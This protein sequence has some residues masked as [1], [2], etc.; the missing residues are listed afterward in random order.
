MFLKILILVDTK[1]KKKLADSHLL[2]MVCMLFFSSV[3]LNLFGIRDQFQGRQSSHRRRQG[4][5]LWLKYMTFTAPPLISQEAELRWACE[6]WGLTANTKETSL[7]RM[8][9][10]SCCVARFLTGHQTVLVHALRVEDPW[11]SWHLN[12][13]VN[14][15]IKSL[16]GSI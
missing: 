15:W 13:F 1:K 10:I 14:F 16:G 12:I 8:P 4:M 11:S 3:V 5:G 7:A 6:Q 9:L 2:R